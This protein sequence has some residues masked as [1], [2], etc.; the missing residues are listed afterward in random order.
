MVKFFRKKKRGFGKKKT[1]KKKAFKRKGRKGRKTYR[2]KK[3]ASY[4]SPHS[5]MKLSTGMGHK[6]SVVQFTNQITCTSSIAGPT[7]DTIQGSWYYTMSLATLYN[8]DFNL[9]NLCHSYLKYRIT[10]MGI[11]IRPQWQ[12]SVNAT[13]CEMGEA[14]VI[15]LHD[16]EP[17][18]RTGQISSTTITNAITLPSQVSSMIQLARE[19]HATRYRFDKPGQ[20]HTKTIKM[21]TFNT[22]IANPAIGNTN[23]YNFE[24]VPQFGKWFDVMDY[25]Q[26]ASIGVI[27]LVQHFGAQ[28]A[29]AGWA[30]N[31]ATQF[32]FEVNTFYEVEFKDAMPY[33][34]F[35]A[36]GS[37]RK[38]VAP[39]IYKNPCYPTHC[40]SEPSRRGEWLTFYEFH[41]FH[42]PDEQKEDDV[43]S[44][45]PTVIVDPPYP[46][47]LPATLPPLSVSSSSSG[48]QRLADLSI[49]ARRRRAVA[50]SPPR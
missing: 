24:Y 7:V 36:Y 12:Q 45:A 22:V 3:S 19:K 9:Q 23:A 47:K 17:I 29:F 40:I 49:E 14:I 20:M 48:L 50:P 28:L 8:Q 27:S 30:T 31:S 41:G 15:P 1:Y 35:T 32:N 21:S 43:L 44:D 13:G 39:I 26:T 46:D 33:Q 34:N 6:K 2:K 37:N 38:V 18:Y 11:T 4:F 25:S 10:K 5:W 16:A 42:H